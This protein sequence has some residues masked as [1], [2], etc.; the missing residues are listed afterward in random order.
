MEPDF[1]VAVMFGLLMITLMF[2]GNMR[3]SHLAL[4]AVLALPIVAYQA[5]QN[6][7]VRNRIA[8]FIANEQR[9]DSEKSGVSEQQRMALIAV[10]SGHMLGVG[11]GEGNQQRGRLALAYNDFIG[12]VIGEEFGFIGITGVTLAFTL[13][14]WLGFRIAERAR[15]PFMSLLAIGLTF[16]TVFTAFIHL[17]VVIG[18]LPNTGLTLPFISFGRSNLVLTLGMTGILVNI[19]SER[20]HVFPNH[21]TDPRIPMAE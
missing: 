13:Y 3:I 5:S 8:S 11:Y 15:S 10:G 17:A 20:E 18:L 19:G 4:L 9:E 21:A 6:G 12:S 16:T 7:Y 1:S 14:G 2:I